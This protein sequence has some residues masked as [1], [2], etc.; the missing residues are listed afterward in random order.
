M[1]GLQTEQFLKPGNFETFYHLAHELSEQVILHLVTIQ[2]R[3]HMLHVLFQITPPS[4]FSDPHQ[5][6]PAKTLTAQLVET[7]QQSIAAVREFFW[8]SLKEAGNWR[9]INQ[10]RW[11][12]YHVAAWDAFFAEFV[13]FMGTQLKQITSLI[14]Q[15]QP[16]AALGGQSTRSDATPLPWTLGE[17]LSLEALQRLQFLTTEAGF[18]ASIFKARTDR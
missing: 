18:E 2:T 13:Q 7:A 14:Q 10:K 15:L 8:P 6:I 12:P 9:E 17:Y 3:T 4:A 11:S 16:A 1:A 5:A